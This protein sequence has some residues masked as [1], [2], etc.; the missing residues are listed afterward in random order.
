MTIGTD[1][2]KQRF[3]IKRPLKEFAGINA[4]RKAFADEAETGLQCNHPNLLR[5]LGLEQD[6]QGTYI[7]LEYTPS[8][9]LNLALVEDSLNIHS[10]KEAKFLMTQLL[11]AVEYLHT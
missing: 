11:D 8:L 3:Y 5:Y 6:E 2:N 10:V 1:T 7:A 4:Y 9:P